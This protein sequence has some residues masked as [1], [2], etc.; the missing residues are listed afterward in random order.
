[1]SERR[2]NII[3]EF[4]SDAGVDNIWIDIVASTRHYDKY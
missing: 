3:I 4:F 1:M 2:Y